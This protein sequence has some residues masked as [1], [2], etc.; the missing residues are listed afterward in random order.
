MN[1]DEIMER[2]RISRGNASM[3]LRSLVEWG[4]V[5]RVHKR[6]DRKEYFEAEQDVWAL[7][8]TIIRERLRRE[9]LPM[10]ATL[11]EIRDQT[12]EAAAGAS[13]TAAASAEQVPAEDVAAHNQRLDQLLELVQT[14]DRLGERFVGSEGKGLRLAASVLS[15]VI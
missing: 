2:L 5:Q 9:I 15:K 14:I 3:S 13:A 12:G 7:A 6:G 1:T 8:R 10:L 11:Y 4:I